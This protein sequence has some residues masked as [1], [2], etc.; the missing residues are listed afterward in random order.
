M[1]EEGGC[2]SEGGEV[3]RVQF[4][5]DGGDGDV[6]WLGEVHGPLVSGVEDDAVEGGM[7]GCNS[8][9]GGISHS[10]RTHTHTH[11][12]TLDKRTGMEGGSE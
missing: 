10:F 3:V 6:I 4:R 2:G 9:R 7:C 11:T 8:I 1:R 12:Y 5:G